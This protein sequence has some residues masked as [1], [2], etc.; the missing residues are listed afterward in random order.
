LIICKDGKD[1]D[2]ETVPNGPEVP[3]AVDR[4]INRSYE[5][6]AEIV[7][8]EREIE[9]TRK[10]AQ[11]DFS[12]VLTKDLFPCAICKHKKEDLRN[13]VCLDCKDNFNFEW[14]GIKEVQP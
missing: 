10:A 5:E 2:I 3:Q 4:L 6:E 13:K 14:R 7:R 1:M 9:Q 11:T 8:L 12:T